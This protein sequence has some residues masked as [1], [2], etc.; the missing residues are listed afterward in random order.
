MTCRL[1]DDLL[2]S[3]SISALTNLGGSL[4]KIHY[5]QHRPLILTDSLHEDLLPR[6]YEVEDAR[7]LHGRDIK[8]SQPLD[9][10]NSSTPCTEVRVNE[11]R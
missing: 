4:V 11:H 3:S 7:H 9:P 2:F 5:F 10:W 1:L 6:C 8:S